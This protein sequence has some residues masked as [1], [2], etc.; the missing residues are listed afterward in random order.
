MKLKKKRKKHVLG[1]DIEGNSVRFEFSDGDSVGLTID[2]I[3]NPN[4]QK[5]LIESL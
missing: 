1:Y 4:S 5:W 2:L 3:K